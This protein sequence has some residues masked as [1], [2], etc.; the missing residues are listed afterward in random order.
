MMNKA[1]GRS[2][3]RIFKNKWFARFARK[4][5]ISDAKLVKIGVYREVKY[6]D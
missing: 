6:D 3:V 2:G 5:G 4:E 1:N